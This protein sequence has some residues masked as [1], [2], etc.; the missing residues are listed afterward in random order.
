MVAN[1][2]PHECV[3]AS[4]LSVLAPATPAVHR[5]RHPVRLVTH[6]WRSQVGDISLSVERC[7]SCS[8]GSLQERP[9][10]RPILPAEEAPTL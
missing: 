8:V 5:L 7:V 1:P 10:N 9:N 2:C 6:A 3:I 4:F